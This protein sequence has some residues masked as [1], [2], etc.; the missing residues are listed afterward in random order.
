MDL[1]VLVEIE[2]HFTQQ[3]II[4]LVLFRLTTKTYVIFLD[5]IGVVPAFAIFVAT[6]L[7][8]AD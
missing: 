2:I 3:S 7:V 1:V 8:E 4:Y 5:F 6:G